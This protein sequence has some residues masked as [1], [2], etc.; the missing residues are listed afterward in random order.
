M[1]SP[2]S[3]CNQALGWLGAKRI[4]SFE[5]NSN[6]ARLCADNYPTLRDALLEERAWTFADAS[7]VLEA[8][9]PSDWNNGDLKFLLPKDI[10]RVYRAYRNVSQGNLQPLPDWRREGK[11]LVCRFPGPVYIR[12]T[13]RVTNVNDW[14]GGFGQALAARI[15]ADLAVPVTKSRKLQA[16]MWNIY[17]L[18]LV[19]AAATDAGQGASERT[20]STELVGVRFG[21]GMGDRVSG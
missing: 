21:D 9:I 4:T 8:P 13:V 7:L 19:A 6:E 5:D 16:D 14:T 2:V 20:D 15:A 12:A 11:Y 1:T 17:E 10:I 18:K 3:I